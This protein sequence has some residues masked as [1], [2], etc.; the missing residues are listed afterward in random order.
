MQFL[1][2]KD[3]YKGRTVTARDQGKSGICLY[4]SGVI[5]KED[6]LALY[7]SSDLIAL[8]FIILFDQS[9]I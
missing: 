7:I 2:I 6:S 5:A 8:D 1:L 4:V 9:D 3:E